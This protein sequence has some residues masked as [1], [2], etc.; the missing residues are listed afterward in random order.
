MAEREGGGGRG[1]GEDHDNQRCQ[2]SFITVT[3]GGV[4]GGGGEIS[5]ALLYGITGVLFSEVK[6]AGSWCVSVN[7][8]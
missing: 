4:G 3:E 1:E 5:F 2:L 8:I 7:L 6:V